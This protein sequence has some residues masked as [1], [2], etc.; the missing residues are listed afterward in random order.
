MNQTEKIAIA[1]AMIVTIV[2]TTFSDTPRLTVPKPPMPQPTTNATETVHYITLKFTQESFTLSI[3]QHLRDAGNTFYM[4]IPTTKKFY[5]SV[6]VGQVL[7][8]KFKG[9]SF[10]LGGHLGCR[11]VYV[12]KKFT[13]KESCQ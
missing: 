4:T 8:E 12:H 13:K 3:S 2:L 6:K 11:K 5:D 9:A 7:G 10:V 1:L